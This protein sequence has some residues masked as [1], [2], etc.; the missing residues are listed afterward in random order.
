MNYRFRINERLSGYREWIESRSNRRFG[1]LMLFV[2]LVGLTAIISSNYLPS[3]YVFL[4]GE[5]APETVV[6]EHTVI[7]ENK[8]ATE[9][10]RRQVAD[11]VAPVYRTNPTA[12]TSVVSEVE[13][14]FDAAQLIKEELA[15]TTTST[16]GDGSVSTGQPQ[17]NL[18]LAKARLRE[19][20]PAA[21]SDDTLAF[22]LEASPLTLT[23][24]KAEIDNSLRQVYAGRV[25]DADLAAEQAVLRGLADSL[26]LP[27]EMRDS[28]YQVAAAY[29]RPN[30][31]YDDEQTRA[32]RD[33]AMKDVAP[34]TVTVL[35]GERVV[36]AGETITPQ[37]LLALQALGLAGRPLS[38]EIWL[39]VFIVVALEL[40]LLAGLLTRTNRKVLEDNLVMLSLTTLILLFNALT[41]V[42]VE[43]PLSPY[44]VPLAA[45][46]MVTTIIT[47]PRTALLVV[48]LQSLN[49]GLMAGFDYGFVLVALLTAVFSLYPVSQL[50]QRSELLSAGVLVSLVAGAAVFASELLQQTAM[51]TA[52]RTS[53]WG[54]A[55]GMISMVLTVSL[56]MIYEPVFNLT[57]PLR[58]L[59]LTNP[60][61]PLLRRLMQVAPGT[62]NHSILMGNLAEAAAEA[63]GADPLLARVGAY[64]H[65]IGKTLRPEYFI[66]NQLHVTNPHDRLNPN[67]S[68][69]A[70][71]AHVRD[72]A[73]LGRMYGLP[74]PVIDIIRQHHGTS[75]LS[76]FYHKA[77]ERSTEQVDEET[78]R[79]EEDKPTS[80]EAAIIMLADSVEAAAK[81]MKNPTVKK[82]Q[83]LIR[84]IFK[85]KV[86]DGQL[87]DSQLTLGDLNKIREVFESGLRGLAGHRIAY[88]KENGRGEARLASAAGGTEASNGASRGR[89]PNLRRVHGGESNA[90]RPGP[91]PGESPAQGGTASGEGA[92]GQG[93]PGEPS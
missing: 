79:Y 93:K 33:Q 23:R 83:G 10:L 34:V 1:L 2:L 5:K 9:E 38:W 59:E 54:L 88:P 63:V 30:Q 66:E 49:V 39:G 91:G 32:R 19:I 16:N 20:A 24:L 35:E 72:G 22:I 60:S 68:R 7:F 62:Y 21:I 46:A 3:R 43:P 27:A 14:L 40:L 76:Y 12:L 50:A 69:L 37:N 41:R 44:V 89:K 52:L 15:P 81:A 71:T 47:K 18:G 86:D 45:L 36:V 11:L 74:R 58:L 51:V 55:N 70:I 26:G 73:G 80:P 56:L 25:T 53:L 65:D 82:M 8:D 64:Y 4:A 13:S 75:V 67:L 48:S 42:L 28:V 84:E 57:T 17:F 92:G 77:Q 31:V 87:D 85:Q 29:L 90:A 78:Y 61:Q 6:A